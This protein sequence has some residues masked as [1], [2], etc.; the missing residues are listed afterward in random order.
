MPIPSEPVPAPA[1]A[2]HESAPES[3][4][5][6]ARPGVRV[7]SACVAVVLLA[8]LLDACCPPLRAGLQGPLWLELGALLVLV[9]ALVRP[10][11]RRTRAAWTTPLDG[12]VLAML[13]LAAVQVAGRAGAPDAWRYLRHVAACAGL[14]VGLVALLRTDARDSDHAWRGLALITVLLGAHALWEATQ[15]SAVLRAHDALVDLRWFGRHALAKT[16]VFATLATAG[17]AAEPGASRR[18][19]LAV[20]VGLAGLAVHAV[21]G[22]FGLDA[23]ALARLDDPL[24]FSTACLTVLGTMVVARRA[25]A[26]ARERRAE[27][28]RWYGLALAMATMGV[29][30]VLGEGTGGEGVRALVALGAAVAVAV[31]LSP[32][33]AERV[34]MGG[35][36]RAAEAPVAVRRAA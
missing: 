32:S 18:W 12:L 21:V 14:Y 6:R 35:L 8:V 33:D 22:G 26:L 25:L 30:G 13:A 24:Y 34:R 10:G 7:A 15:G 4:R 19:R 16:L 11:P 31:A 2:A 36:E 23:R 20:L 28:A 27:R 5:A 3:A 17:R 1:R 9:C 29:S